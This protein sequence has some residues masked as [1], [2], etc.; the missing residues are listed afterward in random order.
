VVKN[1]QLKNYGAF[2]L[3]GKQLRLFFMSFITTIRQNEAL[4][5]SAARQNAL[6]LLTFC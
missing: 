3:C 2:A 1:S 6:F 5:E 4:L